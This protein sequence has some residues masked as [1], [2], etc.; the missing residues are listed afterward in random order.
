MPSTLSVSNTHSL[1]E[2]IQRRFPEAKVVKTLRSMNSYVKVDP[3]QFA[4]ADYTVFVSGR[5]EEAKAK[6]DD[7]TGHGDA[8]PYLV[9]AV[10]CAPEAHLQL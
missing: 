7:S 5:D 8:T 6:V 9:E 1:G 4:E 3:A 10:W 2:Q